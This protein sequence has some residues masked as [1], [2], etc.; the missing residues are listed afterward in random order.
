MWATSGR[1]VNPLTAI[2]MFDMVVKS[3]AEYFVLNA[4]GSQLGY[5]L[6]YAALAVHKIGDGLGLATYA[7]AS[8]FDVV[9]AIGLHSVP[10]TAVMVMIFADRRGPRSGVLRAVGLAC[11]ASLGIAATG[12]VPT[13]LFSDARP[14]LDAAVGGLL[15]HAAFHSR[16]T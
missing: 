12:L 13:Q 4:A 1:V 11:A 2:A 5:E 3:G 15:L 10:L 14:W 8:A 6:G 9:L 16:H 7:N